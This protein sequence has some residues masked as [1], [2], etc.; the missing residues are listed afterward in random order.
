MPLIRR[1][2]KRGFNNANHR[3]EY[4]QINVGTLAEFPAGTVVDGEAL[5]AAGVLRG[6]RALVKVLADGAIDR[7]LVV[8]AHAFSAAARAKIEAAGGECHVVPV[9]TRGSAPKA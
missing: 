8:H 4:H 9:V 3:T 2:P 5:R 1:V 7:R 6:R